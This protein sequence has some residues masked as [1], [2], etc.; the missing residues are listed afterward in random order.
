[1]PFHQKLFRLI[2]LLQI[3][4][5]S[6]YL[7]VHVRE[8]PALLLFSKSAMEKQWTARLNRAAVL[9]P[10]L[11]PA[12]GG[13]TNIKE[14]IVGVRRTSAEDVLVKNVCAFG[15]VLGR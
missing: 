4:G 5:D 14:P 8:T 15:V 10:A 7:V 6:H 12:T 3:V 9:G 11:L 2:E 1:M 13:H